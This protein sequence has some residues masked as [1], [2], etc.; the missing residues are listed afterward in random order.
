MRTRD[1]MLWGALELMR[2]RGASGVSIDAI[3]ER[4]AAPRGS[5]YHHFPGGREQILNEALELAGR[6]VAESID[7]TPSI[8]ATEAIDRLVLLWSGIL[9]ESDF[10]AGCPVVGVI[11]GGGDPA[12]TERANAIYAL[13]TDAVQR[14]L[15]RDS[16]PETEAAGLAAVVVASIE[17]AI[18]SCR[19]TRSLQPLEAVVDHLRRMIDTVGPA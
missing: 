1:R 12:L 15:V 19:A 7:P 4:S 8:S 14:V 11:A 17:G 18:V 13:W 6:W 16:W 3:L 2:E 5:V 9:T 10:T